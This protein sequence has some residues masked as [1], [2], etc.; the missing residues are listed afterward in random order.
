MGTPTNGLLDRA[1]T[2]LPVAVLDFETTGMMAGPDRVVEVSVVRVEPG[3][4][5][6]LVLDTLVNPNRRM[7]CSW[8]HG[9]TDRDVADAPRFPQVAGRVL[10]ALS[11]CVVAAY[12][13]AFDVRFLEF[14]LGRCG[15]RHAFP[16]LCL[17]Y[18]R[19]LLG[20][21]RHCG[22][23][24]ACRIHGIPHT[25]AHAAAA[26]SLAAARLWTVY[27]DAIARRGVRTFADLAALKAYKFV[28]SLCRDPHP[29]IPVTGEGPLKA[30]ANR[31]SGVRGFAATHG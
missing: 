21:G 6:E 5:P 12:N 20:L 11:G 2:D 31:G 24:A 7:G 26:D 18:L 29:G 8:V 25:Q 27:R 10:G 30:R 15:V 1:I 13:A 19:P 22:L 3:R 23:G 17:M 14:E 28:Q 4:G 9:I 16:H